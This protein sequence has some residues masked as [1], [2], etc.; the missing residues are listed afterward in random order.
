MGELRNLFEDGMGGFRPSTD[1]A[2]ERTRRRAERR[3][4]NRRLLAASVALAL[5]ATTLSGLWAAFRLG[6][7]SRPAAPVVP[8]PRIAAEIPLPGPPG[9]TAVAFGHLWIAIPRTGQTPGAVVAID[10]ATNEIV[11]TVTGVSS[12]VDVAA[13]PDALFVFDADTQTVIRVDPASGTPEASF[14]IPINLT[15]A[16]G[17]GPVALAATEDSVLAV[18]E[19]AI[20]LELD[21]HDGSVISEEGISGSGRLL[22]LEIV[23][24]GRWLIFSGSIRFETATT[25]STQDNNTSLMAAAVRGDQAWVAWEGLGVQHLS[26]VTDVVRSYPMDGAGAARVH[27][28]AFEQGWVWLL[29][30]GTLPFRYELVG[31]DDRTETP[32]VRLSLGVKEG[33]AFSHLMQGDITAA[34]GSLWV[35]ARDQ[36]ALL[37]ID[38]SGGSPPAPSPSSSPSVVAHDGECPP[39]ELEARFIPPGVEPDHLQPGMGGGADPD[40]QFPNVIHYGDSP[41]P[42]GDPAL[43]IEIVRTGPDGGPFL[44]EKHARRF[45]D[46]IEVLGGEGYLVSIEDGWGVWFEHGDDPCNGYGIHAYGPTK[47]ET[48]RFAEG[49]RSSVPGPGAIEPSSVPAE[50]GVPYPFTS[51]HCGLSWIVDFDGSFWE[52]L[53]GAP[54]DLLISES[55]GTMT[56]VGADEAL[57]EADEGRSARLRRL[58]GPLV[59]EVCD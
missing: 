5:A 22:D 3:A 21:A 37:R 13:G 17:F 12:P 52:P 51:G 46:P 47:A 14:D 29:A 9:P 18:V 30:D 33:P 23:P 2:L 44:S 57:F 11:R 7:E 31:I 34:Y 6:S 27:G 42:D 49:L 36:Q 32:P 4:R 16:K 53:P 56:L 59:P 20:I 28:V 1:E 25:G 15:R 45:G 58:D 55:S 40:G 38:F 41:G 8:E 39:P 54:E 10:P 24:G 48:R 19:P 35:A 43:F 50:L 26:P